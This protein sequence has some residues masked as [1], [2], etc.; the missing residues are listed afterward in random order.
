[1][2][3]RCPVA[4]AQYMGPLIETLGSRTGGHKD[5]QFFDQLFDQF[6]DHL[7]DQKTHPVRP[8]FGPQTG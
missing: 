4:L 6:F 5:D 1:M 7:A 3:I 2:R 8:I